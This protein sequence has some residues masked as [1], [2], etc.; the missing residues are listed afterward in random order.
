[1]QTPISVIFLL[2]VLFALL[3]AG[4]SKEEKQPQFEKKST[5][6]AKP[7]FAEPSNTV[8]RALSPSSF[9]K[10]TV[11]KPQRP[12]SSNQ[13]ILTVIDTT[14]PSKEN[15]LDALSKLGR[16]LGENDVQTLMD[17][18]NI[19]NDADVL[20]PE[21]LNVVKND[22]TNLLRSQRQFPESLSWR[23]M[24]MWRDPKHDVVWR[25]YCIQH[26]GASIARIEDA[27]TRAE[28]INFFYDVAATP[29]A[30]GSGTALIALRNLVNSGK[31]D[32]VKVAESAIIAAGSEST[33]QGVR[34]TALQIASE[35]GHPDAAPIARTLVNDRTKTM[36]LRV[37]AIAAL[38]RSGDSSDLPA[39]EK[40]A[41]SSNYRL[42]LAAAAA[43]KKLNKE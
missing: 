1:M 42:R 5:P 3:F 39:L 34:V 37:S 13:D 22:I 2:P 43:V 40:L 21:K 19:Y 18:L 15:R 14:N 25:D 27:A 12:A 7:T 31:E 35:L 9:N 26:A 23:L 28:S 8:V 16:E 29:D 41:N 24:S 20:P 30:P 33:P 17:F 10:A 11:E 36:H 4:C 32:K 38:G 6:H